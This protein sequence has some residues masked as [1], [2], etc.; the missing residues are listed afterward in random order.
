MV[1][2]IN[3]L[4][5]QSNIYVDCIITLIE[6]SKISTEATQVNL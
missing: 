6:Q 1:K 3:T 2:K 5:E 4:L